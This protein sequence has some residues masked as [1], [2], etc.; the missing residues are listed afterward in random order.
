MC[1]MC[2]S[3]TKRIDI[4][5]AARG[6]A[7]VSPLMNKENHKI[8]RFGEFMIESIFCSGEKFG[9]VFLSPSTGL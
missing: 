5:D 6:L 2:I 4:I 9:D 8:Y 7:A 3:M 1:I